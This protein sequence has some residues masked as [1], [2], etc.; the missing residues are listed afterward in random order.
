MSDSGNE[1]KKLGELLVESG[2]IPAEKLPEG[3]EYARAN[4]L[5][6]GRVLLT[7]HLLKKEDLES[8]LHSQ[9]LIKVDQLPAAIAAKAIALSS[10]ENISIDRALKRLGWQPDKFVQGEPHSLAIARE[11]V[12]TARAAFGPYH[13]E[14][15]MAL[16]NYADTCAEEEHSE[17]AETAYKKTISIVE[18]CFGTQSPEMAAVL[19]KL[20]ELYFTQDRFKESEQYFWRTYE[21]KQALL[22]DDAM[23]VAECLQSLAELYEVQSEYLQ[24]ERY[25]L[26]SIGIKE[27]ILEADDPELL[28][29]L[30]KLVLVC[31][32]RQKRPEQKVTGEVIV[33]AGLLTR[34]KIDEALELA[35]KYNIPIG[36]T[37]VSMRQLAEDDLQRVLHARLLMLDGALPASIVIRALKWASKQGTSVEQ[38]LR[39]MGW[40][41]EDTAEQK[42]LESLLK[43]SEELVRLEKALTPD[44]TDVGIKCVELADLYA[45]ANNCREAEV[46]LGRALR[47]FRDNLSDSDMITANTLVNL[48]DILT[49]QGKFAEAET[50]L[51]EALSITESVLGK[52]SNRTAEVLQQLGKLKLMTTD[53]TGALE[54]YRR[55]RD[56][57]EKNSNSDPGGLSNLYEM[58]GDCL[59]HLRDHKSAV[60]SYERAL[61]LREK[62]TISSGNPQITGL[63]NKIGLLYMSI[64]DA[65]SAI[66]HY[67]RAVELTEKAV[68]AVHPSI[69]FA[70]L[71]LADASV[72]LKDHV[73][74][75]QH[76]RRAVIIIEQI[77]GPVHEDTAKVLEHYMRFLNDTGMTEEATKIDRRIREIRTAGA[78]RA[79]VVQLRPVMRKDR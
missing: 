60:E 7:W 2:L 28:E 36:R 29:S 31:K 18:Q 1:A 4:K 48:S 64:G 68:G 35:K 71:N 46:L 75:S 67:E 6:L 34:E 77:S 19:P 74:A 14:T 22:G 52:A 8:A 27:R 37:L 13:P 47:I 54:S 55:S 66:K 49:R 42:Q 78:P 30:K 69:A 62:S 79:T 15:A 43:S 65:V 3:L 33:D 73:Q 38:A 10:R 32:Q 24:A 51:S 20:A 12:N 5:P 11:E 76:Y 26:A 44:H 25:Y 41:K 39:A 45:G 23:E 56:I 21:I 70:L 61:V 9:A 53:F 63:E 16:L 17:E 72:A 57:C 50:D 58:E 59:A 40:K